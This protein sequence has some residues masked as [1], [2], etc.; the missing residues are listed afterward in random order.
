[1]TAFPSAPVLSAG[2]DFLY[3]AG[4]S[5]SVL[6][7][8]AVDGS[9]VWAFVTGGQHEAEPVLSE[10]EG[11]DPVLYTI[12]VRMLILGRERVPLTFIS[13]T[14]SHQLKRTEIDWLDPS[15]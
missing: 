3:L 8:S 6:C 2:E 7:V 11:E 10:V 5:A 9:F 14:R 13:H 4:A 1:L 15:V 12:E